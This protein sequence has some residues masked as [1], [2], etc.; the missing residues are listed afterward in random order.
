MEVETQRSEN[1]PPQGT[2]R[3]LTLVQSLCAALLSLKGNGIIL[4]ALVLILSTAVPV[5]YTS[6]LIARTFR[7]TLCRSRF[8]LCTPVM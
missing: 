8:S 3:A 2:K 1:R 6:V 5:V 4:S 7:L